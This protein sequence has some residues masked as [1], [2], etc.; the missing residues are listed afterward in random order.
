MTLA[1]PRKSSMQQGSQV[2]KQILPPLPPKLMQFS[3]TSTKAQKAKKVNEEITKEVEQASKAPMKDPM[4]RTP[5]KFSIFF[6]GKM[7]ILP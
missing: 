6:T 2:V 1:M 3:F 4:V 7:K 5:R